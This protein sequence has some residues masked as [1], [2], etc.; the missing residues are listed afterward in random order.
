MDDVSVLEK[1]FSAMGARVKFSKPNERWNTASPFTI[2]IQK[3]SEGEF[4]DVRVKK[5]IEMMIMDLQKQDRHL[6]LL[7]KNPNGNSNFSQ[8]DDPRRI[9]TS[10]FLCGHD[11]RHWFTCAVPGGASTVTQAK[12]NLKPTELQNIEKKEGLKSNRAHKRHRKLESGRKIHRQGEFMFIPEPDF[13]P[14][15]SSLTVIHRREPM[16]RGRGRSHFAEFLYRSGGTQ[17]YL[18]SY[19]NKSQTIGLTEKEFKALRRED[20]R[21]P[22]WQVRQ[23][24][25]NVWVKGKITHHEHRTVDLGSIWHR[26]TMNTEN[27]APGAR[28]VAFLD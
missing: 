15:E 14:P 16:S 11:E 12:Q 2:D 7:V 19:N 22:G 6:L 23:A 13:Q 28:Q 18:S 21:R 5:E 10:R 3:D 8:K 4:F 17:V 9:A 24:D 27:L 1:K 26:V 25:A 20:Q